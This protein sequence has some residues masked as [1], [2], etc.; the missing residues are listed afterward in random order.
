MTAPAPWRCPVAELPPGHTAAFR[1]G[2]AGGTVEGFVVNH[3][4]RYHAYVNRCPHRGTSLD[5]W[6]NEF[7]SEDRRW[8]ICATH[9]AVFEPSTGACVAGPCA[10]DVLTPLAVRVEDGAVVVTGPSR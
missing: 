6:P 2:G 10:G 4:G 5:A 1:L 9:G 7:L 8:L 3:G